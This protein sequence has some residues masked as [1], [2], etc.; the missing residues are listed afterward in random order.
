MTDSGGGGTGG[1]GGAG[2]DGGESALALGAE[3]SVPSQC[4]SGWCTDGV[5]CEVLCDGGCEACDATGKCSPHGAGQDPE[6]VCALATCDGS[7]S[8]GFGAHRWSFLAKAPGDG[9]ISD[10][11]VDS[12]GN[13]I[14][15]GTFQ[16]ALDIAGLVLS[17]AGQTDLFVVKVGPSGQAIWGKR[18][19]DA[20]AQSAT[21]VAMD[22]AGN[23]YVAG[24]TCGVVD[25]GGA[26]SVTGSCNIQSL[27]YAEGYLTKL[28]GNGNGLWAIV[29]NS[30]GFRSV[31]VD[32]SG[33]AVYYWASNAS[34]VIDSASVVKRATTTGSQVWQYAPPGLPENG[35]L[36]VTPAGQLWLVAGFSGT[37]DFDTGAKTSNDDAAFLARL[38]PDGTELFVEVLGDGNAYPTGLRADGMGGLFLTGYY[39]SALNLGGL[40]LPTSGG[41]DAFVAHFDS[42]AQ[43]IWSRGVGG[44]ADDRGGDMAFFSDGSI[45]WVGQTESTLDFGVG[46]HIPAGGGDAFVVRLSSSGTT[47]W[48]HLLGGSGQDELTRVI[49]RGDDLFAVGTTDGQINLGGG[50]LFPSDGVEGMAVRLGP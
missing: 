33:T 6:M 44:G 5:C 36:T 8:C 23:I 11:T 22:A 38:D 7:G 12:A 27:N 46:E 13:A 1:P 35:L 3:C 31:T 16:G 41:W 26:A 24:T 45:A 49:V 9:A 18:F 14:V 47:M 48:S 37:V 10:V 32:S 28:D 15:V 50:L 40:V 20:A 42:T 19:G 29:G 30:F 4:E 34:P 17:S 25:F 43:H 39:T 21:S 2:G